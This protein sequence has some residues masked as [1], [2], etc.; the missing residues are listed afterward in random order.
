LSDSIV[1]AVRITSTAVGER[2]A[3]I[4]RHAMRDRDRA[5]SAALDALVEDARVKIET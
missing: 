4:Y 1:A 3:M 2:A 5:I